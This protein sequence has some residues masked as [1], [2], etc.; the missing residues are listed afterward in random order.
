[1]ELGLQI[2]D[3]YYIPKGKFLFLR[4]TFAKYIKINFCGFA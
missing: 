1:M 4:F 2:Y 3:E